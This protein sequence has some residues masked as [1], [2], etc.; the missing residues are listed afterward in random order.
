MCACDPLSQVW[1]VYETRNRFSLLKFSVLNISKSERVTLYIIS[2]D[3]I[4]KIRDFVWISYHDHF[5]VPD[6]RLKI[7]FKGLK[8]LLKQDSAQNE[9]SSS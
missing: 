4:R 8:L 6:P 2:G 7:G 3:I 9:A 1:Y 5:R